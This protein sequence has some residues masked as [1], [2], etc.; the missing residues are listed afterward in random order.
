MRVQRS[1]QIMRWTRGTEG[2]I[3][4]Q[5]K[6][7]REIKG[8]RQQRRREVIRRK[9]LEREQGRRRVR[10]GWQEKKEEGC[11]KNNLRNPIKSQRPAYDSKKQVDQ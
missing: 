7:G 10:E 6:R 11:S 3:W 4:H 1:K 5:E 9:G 2:E 8:T